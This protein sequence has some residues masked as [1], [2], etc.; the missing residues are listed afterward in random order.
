MRLLT[1]TFDPPEGQGGIEGRAMAYTARLLGRGIHVEVAALSPHLGKSEEKYQGTVLLRLPSS[2]IRLPSTLRSLIRLMSRSS[3]DS[4]FMLSGGS[5]GAGIL[6][7]CYSRLT[8]RRSAVLFYGRDILQ[9]RRRPAGRISLLLAVLLANGVGANSRYTS[10]LLPFRRRTPPVIVYP[11]VD[12]SLASEYSERGRDRNEPRLLFV[13][14]LVRRKGADLLIEAFG[15]LRADMPSVRLDIVGDGPELPNLIALAR[16][17][18]LGD[19]VTFHGALFGR[20]LWEVYAKAALLVLPSRQSAYDVEG[21]GTV[22]LE[23]GMFGIPSIGTRTGGIPEA[24]V[25]GVTGKLVRDG[26]VGELGDAIKS[27]L[28]DPE[29]AERLGTNARAEALRFSWDRSTDQVLRL[30]GYGTGEK[31]PA[32][33]PDARG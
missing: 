23:A 7:L 33:R 29:E 8:G 26:N 17:L 31:T 13:G 32:Q 3:L 6:V 4:V 28:D 27:L 20:R 16:K 14:R 11:G 2:L 5:T 15:R 12:T 21:F 25:D 1:V 30:L 9:S 22:F 18:D 24:V 10:S 19:A